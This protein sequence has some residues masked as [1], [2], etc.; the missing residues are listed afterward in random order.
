[1]L[2]FLKMMRP[3][4]GQFG[5]RGIVVSRGDSLGKF[6]YCK[7]LSHAI[8]CI[9]TSILVLTPNCNIP[10]IF[11]ACDRINPM[12]PPKVSSRMVFRVSNYWFVYL[13]IIL[14]LELPVLVQIAIRV[15]QATKTLQE[16]STKRQK[17]VAVALII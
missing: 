9:T 12:L 7:I 2:T 14:D 6:V 3:N 8:I 13:S 5:G 1:M 17:V 16:T 10:V 11:M 4:E 15:T